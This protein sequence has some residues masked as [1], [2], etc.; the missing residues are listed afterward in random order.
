MDGD[1]RKDG[2]GRVGKMWNRKAMRSEREKERILAKVG[3]QKALP[4]L[5][6]M[7]VTVH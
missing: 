6:R 4:E 7:L 5:S 1:G 3:K 2:A